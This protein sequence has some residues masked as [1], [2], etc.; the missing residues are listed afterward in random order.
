VK[1]LPL[2]VLSSLAIS[3]E[4]H[5]AVVAGKGLTCPK[6]TIFKTQS[7]P[8]KDKRIDWCESTDGVKEGPLRVVRESS[9]VVTADYVFRAGKRHGVSHVFYD[10]GTLLAVV[11]YENGKET[12]HRFTLEGLQRLFDEKNEEARQAGKRV[13]MF[14]VDEH[15]LKYI[16]TREASFSWFSIDKKDTDKMVEKM[17]SHPDVCAL[18]EHPAIRL[19]LIRVQY[20]DT[21]GVVQGELSI[22]RGDCSK[23]P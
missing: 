7:V 1:L 3:S 16:I 19:E 12:D 14:L 21:K 6:G 15:T 4:T 23:G 10:D 9:G 13:Q 5:S 20:V 17:T 2:L 18:F 22:L 11:N 8:V